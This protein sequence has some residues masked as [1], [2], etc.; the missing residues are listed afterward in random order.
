MNLKDMSLEDLQKAKQEAEFAV[1]WEENKSNPEK[2]LELI[3][4]LEADIARDK[5]RR[6]REVDAKFQA[7]S[8][9]HDRNYNAN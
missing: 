4:M 9:I 5:E 7:E 2:L 6:H 8:R 1:W 3:H